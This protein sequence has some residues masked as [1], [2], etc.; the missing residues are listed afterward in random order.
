MP[1]R[2]TKLTP[3]V[4]DKIVSILRSGSSRADAAVFA[5]VCRRTVEDWMTQGAGGSAKPALKEFSRRVL[6]AEISAKIE[7]VAVITKAAREGD[8]K[9]ALAFLQCRY[10]AEWG[11]KSHLTTNAKVTHQQGGDVPW[12]ELGEAMAAYPEA[13]AA[14][15]EVLKRAQ[16]R[17]KAQIENKGAGD[18][19]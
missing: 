3:A 17:Q 10:G 9:A 1:G 5:G 15:S 11:A 8:W 19:D 4:T 7:M 2:P 6:E 14:F 13:K 12:E 18:G 16:E